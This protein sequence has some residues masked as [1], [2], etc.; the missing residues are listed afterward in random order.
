MKK[1]K[2]PPAAGGDNP[3][4][5][6]LTGKVLRGFGRWLA[7]L[8][9]VAAC[10]GPAARLAAA[11]DAV[12][13]EVEPRETSLGRPAT[14]RVLV[15][16]DALA[17]VDTSPVTDFAVIPRG[18]VVGTRT[19]PDGKSGLVAAYRFE[20]APRHAGD[21]VVPA[22]AVETGGARLL[23]NPV[24]VRVRP[25][26]TV[27]P[28]L[29]GKTLLLD[30]ALSRPAAYLGQSL[31]YSL[32][33]FRSVAAANIVVTPPAFDGFAATPLPGQTDDEIEAGGRRYAVSRVDY[34]LT[35]LRAGRLPL[36]PASARLTGLPG[37]PRPMVV[38]SL[39][40]AVEARPLPP[41]PDG[42]AAAGLVGRMEL[43]ARLVSETTPVGQEAIL[44]VTLS[45]Q[46]NL[47]EAT[48]PAPQLPEG[49]SLRRL[50]AE[51]DG[52]M[53][54]DGFSGRR[55]V[56]FALRGDHPGRYALPGLRL[57]VFDPDRNVWQTLAAPDLA[58]TVTAPASL[59]AA[60]APPLA[61]LEG[62]DPALAGAR[63]A[64]A[65]GRFAEAAEG[66]DAALAGHWRHAG[67]Q[68]CLDAATAWRLAGAPG[69]TALWLYRAELSDPGDAR[70]L[71]ALAAAGLPRFAPGLRLGNRLPPGVVQ[72]AALLAAAG[73]VLAALIGR[74]FALRLP[75]SVW[76]LAG[77]AAL[78]LALEAGW[79]ALA[80]ILAPRAVATAET[81]VRCAPEAGAETL[82]VLPPGT[83]V[84]LGRQ[85]DGFVRIDAG[86]DALGWAVCDAAVTRLQ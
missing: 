74:R 26:P 20:L 9:I 50:P 11:A 3:P 16:G 6:P 68:A 76:L 65:A 27:P 38:S 33:L 78:W 19:G 49:I 83:M 43:D 79:L 44:A 73:L 25:G 8:T 37:E 48:L 54:P 13:A 47:T 17:V 64:Y 72:A 61:T 35:P 60:L 31:V 63:E 18:R 42:L 29:I 46:G 41:A 57:A 23:T 52:G 53:G 59:P 1:R 4:R 2:M 34:A 69:R 55:T 67:T 24:A 58:L 62:G 28:G 40:L 14:L 45:G 12:T 75:R 36:A 71:R 66:L 32:R 77:T 86:Y 39:G 15:P 30:A 84:R 56:R 82:F 7:I 21:C 22:L 70:V 5:T 10:L 81:T 51:D 80:P 85:R